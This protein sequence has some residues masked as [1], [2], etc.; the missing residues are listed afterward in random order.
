[1]E[2]KVLIRRF[3]WQGST[4]Q[5]VVQAEAERIVEE[6]LRTGAL[7]IDEETDA[8]LERLSPE[9]GRVFIIKPIAGGTGSQVV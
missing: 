5:E 7:V 1:M 3:G 9:V 6:A 2:R 8:R 4:V